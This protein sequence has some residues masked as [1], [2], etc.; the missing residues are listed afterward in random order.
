MVELR[1]NTAGVLRSVRQGHRLLLTYRG[2]AVARIEPVTKRPVSSD[3]PIYRLADL[4]VDA[5][6]PITN[7][8]IDDL[9]Y[10]P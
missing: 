3:D 10:G 9:V 5:G 8:A 6:A 7:D 2:E 1:R 4:A